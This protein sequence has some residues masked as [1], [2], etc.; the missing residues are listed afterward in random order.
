MRATPTHVIPSGANA[1]EG[2][3]AAPQAR[4]PRSARILSVAALLALCA[5]S[6]NGAGAPNTTS[7]RGFARSDAGSSG[8]IA[9]IVIIMQENRSFDNLFQ[10]FPG[11]NTQSYGYTS[12]G[13]KVSLQPVP[14]GIKWDV[15]HSSRAYFEACDGQ[16]SLPGTNCK[17]D[18]FDKEAVSCRVYPPCPNDH[19]Q[20]S[21]APKSETKPYVQMAK[22]YVLADNTFTSNFDASSFV[23]HQ[24]II[25][26]QADSTIDYPLSVWGCGG[27][28]QDTIYQVTQQRTKTG[29]V[30]A[31]FDYPTLGDEL[32][33][34]GVS[35]K[36]YTSKLDNA[37]GI[38][39]AYQAVQHI[40]YGPDW[41]RD[42]ATPQTRF[43]KDVTN[44]TL[45]AVSW[46]MPTCANSDHAGCDTNHGP[47]WVA[48]I[49]NAVGSSQYWNSAAIFVMW[50]DY[51]G[52]YDHVPPPLVD[53]DGLGIRVPL[54][55]ISPF[56]K[57]GYVSHVQYE[58]GSILK[59]V[60]DQFGLARLS[61][62]DA[63]ATSPEGDCFDFSRAPRRFEPIPAILKPSYF[64]REAPD[65]RPP[66]TE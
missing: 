27:G 30:Q 54:L 39:S 1:V 48:S 60:E 28:K 31:C 3:S 4:S 37:S 46:V 50:D 43:F 11:A 12:T 20:Y 5:C 9:H 18:G 65:L 64:E 34:A 57:K 14:L 23:S 19:P 8:K 35:W 36:Y 22:Q 55:V 61:A 24:Y 51:G 63:R 52:W 38:W 44:G 42:V 56:A 32:D 40:R 58:H 2:Q 16:G 25:A 45:P 13:E 10:G 41:K 53:Y 29:P 7:L 17:M 26:A 49:V 6:A 62:S 66:D 15:D 21:Y 47:Q 33:A 59:F